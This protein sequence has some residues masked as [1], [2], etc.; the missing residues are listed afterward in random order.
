MSP[1]LLETSALDLAISGN[2]RLCTALELT[3]H[4]GE[5]IAILGRN[6]VGK[7]SLLTVLAGLRHTQLV[8]SGEIRLGGTPYSQLTARAAAQQRGWLA[9][10]SHNDFSAHVFDIALMGRYPHLRRW[11]TEHANDR[12][13][14]QEALQALGLEQCA[15]QDIQTLSGG[16]RQ[17]LAIATLLTQ[18]PRLY[19]LDEPLAHLDLN[20]QINVMDILRQRACQQGAGIIM[21]LHDP[22]LAA[23]Y[24][25]RVLLMT[26][27]ADG[28]YQIGHSHQLLNSTQLSQLYGHPLSEIQHDGKRYF[29]P[30]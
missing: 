30:A 2:K 17:R 13:L 22:N 24:C 28:D 15:E 1:V 8:R 20:H 19:L 14:A 5:S 3:V 21:V 9:Q 7:S 18:N 16:E 10:Q 23:R 29:V 4:A 12:A 11:H 26:G 6:G 27:N 25:D